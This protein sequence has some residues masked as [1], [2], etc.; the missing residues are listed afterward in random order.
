[1][2]RTYSKLSNKHQKHSKVHYKAYLNNLSEP[3][4]QLHTDIPVE[5][6]AELMENSALMRQ[7]FRQLA[8]SM[9]RTFS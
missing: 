2:S 6:E 9:R 3:R 8:H 5:I 7:E 4:D 1:M